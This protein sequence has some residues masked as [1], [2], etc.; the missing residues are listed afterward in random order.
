MNNYRGIA[1]KLVLVIGAWS[2]MALSRA[3]ADDK[4]VTA[5]PPTQALVTPQT[6]MPQQSSSAVHGVTQA[7]VKSGVLICASR[8][9]QLA[10][11]LTAGSQG[12]GAFLFTAPADPDQRLVSVSMEIPAVVNVPTAY[13]SASFA[14]NQANGCGG[15]YESV[16]Y[17]SQHC[18][19]VAGKNF[20]GLVKAGTLSKTITVLD[21]G[22]AT[23]IFLMPAGSG[24]V[25]I[26]KDIVQ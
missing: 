2:C 23:K 24:C 10:N 26:K 16:I 7:A 13:A 15:M 1:M 22:V 12:V 4:F 9:N 6:P 11:F 8:I 25:S 19:E 18:D 20:A 5:R 21:G 14:P 3:A 17:W